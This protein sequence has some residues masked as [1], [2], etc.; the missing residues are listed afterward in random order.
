MKVTSEKVVIIALG[1]N[2]VIFATKGVAAWLSGSSALFSE[3]LHSLADSLNSVLLLIGIR[4]AAMP[5]DRRHP[6]GYTR[7]IYFWSFLGAVFMFG[8]IA[9][10][11]IYRGY[12]QILYSSE[13]HHISWALATLVA[14]IILESVAVFYAIR[15]LRLSS[16][17]VNGRKTGVLASF[18]ESGDPAV[19]LV[20]VEDFL[21]LSGVLMAFGGLLAVHF[22]GAPKLDGFTAVAIGLLIGVLAVYL[23]NEN[24]KKLLGESASPRMEEDI[25]KHA[26]TDPEIHNVLS[27]K[28]IQVGANKVMAYLV[29]ELEPDLA[30]EDVDDITYNLEKRIIREIPEVIDCFI[31]V[32]ATTCE[33]CK[34]RIKKQDGWMFKGKQKEV[35]EFADSR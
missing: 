24:R 9:S 7:A 21:S 28:T 5:P 2:L 33:P 27:L 3:T 8:V 12:E 1:C 11:S 23:M 16:R 34:E 10:G 6:F 25:R 18:R 14:S 31:E 35:D 13:I 29:V 30:V 20:F 15:G 22:F 32:V 19:K 26:M 17:P 4:R